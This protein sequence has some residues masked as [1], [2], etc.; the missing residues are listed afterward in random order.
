MGSLAVGEIAARP[1]PGRATERDGLW[2]VGR[3]E[4][5]IFS[6]M[7]KDPLSE[8]R[9][10]AEECRRLAETALTDLDRRLMLALAKDFDHKAD[11]EEAK[12]RK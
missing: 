7:A 5:P 3:D 12:R 9:Q 2:P 1:F 8:Y 6:R 4:S 10:K 11:A